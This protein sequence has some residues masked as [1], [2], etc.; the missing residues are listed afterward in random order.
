ML[1]KA[2]RNIQISSNGIILKRVSQYLAYAD[3]A[4]MLGGTV[5]ATKIQLQSKH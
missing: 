4:V 5:A 1:D 3:G 2:I